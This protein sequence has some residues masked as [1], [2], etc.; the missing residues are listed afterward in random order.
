MIL[1][2]RLTSHAIYGMSCMLIASY[3]KSDQ[4]KL[5]FAI[6]KAIL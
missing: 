3:F 5:I 2:G 4:Q 6:Y 1:E